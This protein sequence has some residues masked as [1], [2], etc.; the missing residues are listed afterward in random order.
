MKNRDK[1]LD[2]VGAV[3]HFQ[4]FN[5]HHDTTFKDWEEIR[6]AIGY[7]H[8]QKVEDFQERYETWLKTHDTLLYKA[9][10]EKS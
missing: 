1:P 7:N 9:L 6:Q 2:F 10:N 4:E 3:M 5:I 8:L